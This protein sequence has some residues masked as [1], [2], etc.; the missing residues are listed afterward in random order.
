MDGSK[1]TIQN[2][3]CMNESN[4]EKY[5]RKLVPEKPGGPNHLNDFVNLYEDTILHFAVFH[6]K[7]K[8]VNFLLAN[9]ADPTIKNKVK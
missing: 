3:F 2:F 1:K 7:E 5:L 8:I 9:G 6:E 4:F